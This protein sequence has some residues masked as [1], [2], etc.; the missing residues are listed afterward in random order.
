MYLGHREMDQS[1]EIDDTF[2][3]PKY[4]Y[5]TVGYALTPEFTD[6]SQ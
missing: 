2:V 6:A 1:E 3:K 5:W 4:P